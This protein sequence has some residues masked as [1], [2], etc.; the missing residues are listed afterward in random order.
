M[1]RIL[2]IIF[3]IMTNDSISKDT[4]LN[5]YGEELQNCCQDPLTGYFRDGSCRTDVT[6][7]GTHTVCAI[8]TDK[9]LQYTLS[10]GN[11]LISA[12]RYFP[13]LKLGDKWCLCALRWKE[14]FNEG[15]A[16]PLDLE[17]TNIKTLDF[18]KYD[19]LIKYTQDKVLVKQIILD[20]NQKQ[21]LTIIFDKKSNQAINYLSPLILIDNLEV[22]INNELAKNIDAKYFYEF[23]DKKQDLK[24]SK[25]IV[26]KKQLSFKKIF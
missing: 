11:D 16:P 3:T 14:A 24:A 23:F 4:D 7:R 17:A 9:F 20:L 8:I 6:D 19:D 5:I 13:G 26:K 12:N 2:I 10:K 25:F 18:L 1:I 15:Y 21:D 22:Y